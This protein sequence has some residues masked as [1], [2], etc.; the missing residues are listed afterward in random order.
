MPKRL[1][2]IDDQPGATQAIGLIARQLGL[3]MRGLNN[4]ANALDVFLEYRPDILVLDMIM[5]EKDGI[6]VLHEI[7]MT[8]IPVQIVLVSGFGASFLRLAE[9][10]ARFHGYDHVSVLQKPFRREDISGLL[11]RLTVQSTA[12]AYQHEPEL[13]AD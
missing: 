3:D 5:P 8:G 13:A 1:L 7:L 6:D 10:V 2:V 9:N 4:S 11:M 12:R